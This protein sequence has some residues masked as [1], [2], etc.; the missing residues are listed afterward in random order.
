[1][2]VRREAS[3]YVCITQPDHAALA[4]TLV[5]AWCADGLPT[6]PTRAQVVEATRVHDIG[7]T[8][9]DVAPR[10]DPESG[11]PFD[12]VS[13][14]ID[15]RQGIWP[16]AIAALAPHDPYVAALVAQHALTVYRRY[17]HDAAWRGF[18]APIE[19]LRDDLYAE[20]AVR[21]QAAGSGVPLSFLQDYSLVGIGDLFS[22]VFCNGWTEPHLIEGYQAILRDNVLT[23]TPD[24]FGG[25]AVAFEVTAR[26]LPLRRYD[27]DAELRAAWAEARP[28]SI[29]GLAVGAQTAPAP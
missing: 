1:M 2:I 25:L 10:A 29:S 15:V 12:F 7:W 18:F 9:E 5:E 17:Q 23:V 27:S 21:A 6:R 16:R 20:A 24:P 8:I 4:G 28:V 14:P 13:A 19:R 26:R 22:L 3:H 11:A